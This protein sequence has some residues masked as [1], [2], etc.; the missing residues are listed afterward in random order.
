MKK[1]QLLALS[2]LLSTPVA[3]TYTAAGTVASASQSNR[4][5]RQNARQAHRAEIA[6]AV[7]S[8]KDAFFAADRDLQ[9]AEV[10][11]GQNLRDQISEIN[12]TISELN[13]SENESQAAKSALLNLHQ[14]RDTLRSR[15]ERHKY[16][17]QA[18]KS[19]LMG[20]AD[21]IRNHITDL[22]EKQAEAQAQLN[23]QAQDNSRVQYLQGRIDEIKNDI[24]MKQSNLQA[25]QV[26]VQSAQNAMD[27]LQDRKAQA[28]VSAVQNKMNS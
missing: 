16:K 25:V 7:Q 21:S 9:N 5:A 13:L 12:D 24:E 17:L 19:W 23:G 28:K 18:R 22:Q 14:E 4:A 20:R 26:K 15:L 27:A 2:M 6:A 1:L 3:I 10:E 11:F 8:K